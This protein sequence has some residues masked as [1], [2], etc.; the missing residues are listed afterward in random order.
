M[1]VCVCM[2]G[3]YRCRTWCASLHK[4]GS[5]SSLPSVCTTESMMVAPFWHNR[6][7]RLPK[8][9]ARALKARV[10]YQAGDGLIAYLQQQ[11]QGSDCTA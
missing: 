10:R 7:L 8:V 9:V 11:M 5:K 4:Q 1:D 6:R 2:G 3:R